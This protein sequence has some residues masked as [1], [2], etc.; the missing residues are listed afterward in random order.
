[1]Y[2]GADEIETAPEVMLHMIRMVFPNYISSVMFFDDGSSCSIITHFL[3]GFLFAKGEEG[4]LEHG[5]GWL[6]FR[7]ARDLSVQVG[8]H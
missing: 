5:G 8:D 6:I 4:H 7:E 2:Q 3:A 1:M